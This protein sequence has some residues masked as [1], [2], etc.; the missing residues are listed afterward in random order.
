[1]ATSPHT[2][3][4]PSV[5]IVGGGL[6][7]LAGALAATRRGFRVE[8]FEARKQLGGR[9]ASFRDPRTGALVDY[10]QHVAMGCCTSLLDFCRRTGIADAFSTHKVLHF[11][12]PDGSQC[13]FRPSAFLPAPLHLV[14]ALLR[15]RFLTLRERWR[16]VRALFQLAR[17]VARASEQT[18]GQWLRRHGQSERAIE[19]FWSVVL[20]S[21][22]SETVDRASLCAAQKVF[23]DGFLAS[24]R[25]Y[26]LL[27]PRVPLSDLLDC[28]VG[29]W[30][31]EHGVAVRRGTSVRQ[32]DGDS[33]RATAVVLA[34]GTRRPFDFI[35]VAVPW[36]Q[37]R[38]LFPGPMLAAMPMLSGAEDLPPAP[39]TAV[40]LWFDRPITPL[41]H[42]VLVGR[43]S[44]WVFQGPGGRML[45]EPEA[46]NA[47]RLAADATSACAGRPPHYCQ[48]VISASHELVN[49]PRQQIIA[50]VRE[51]LESIW[52]AARG[53]ELLHCR[54]ITHHAAVFSMRPGVDRLRPPQQTP[55]ANLLLAGDWTA[56]GW[57]A[58]M[59]SAVRSG[60]LAV[61]AIREKAALA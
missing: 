4:R 12:G 58:T 36:R 45:A 20:I 19:R 35:I 18:I 54:V 33:Q 59:E 6:S 17:G 42:A 37:V 55:I 14:P 47:A 44:Q 1:M 56:T 10:C 22:L 27:V 46:K 52:P 49:R 3:E 8:L 7:G 2:L 41:P 31:S 23:V 21:A 34:D 53:A 29:T 9:A 39:I 5:A 43:T 61:E 28:R 15:L 25:A 13:D 60:Y 51:D 48:V 11:I 50:E 30:L 32:I 26:E 40:H 16:I 24:R 38:S 57:P